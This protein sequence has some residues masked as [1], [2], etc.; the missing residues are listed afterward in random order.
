MAHMRGGLR[1]T[2]KHKRTQPQPDEQEHDSRQDQQPANGTTYPRANVGERE[3]L[4]S[5]IMGVGLL[6]RS[7]RHSFSPVGALGAIGGIALLY[8]AATGYCPAYHALGRGTDDQAD[9]SRI[10]RRKVRTRQ[11][12]KVEESIEIDKPREELYAFWRKLENLPQVMSHVVS[13]TPLDERRSHWTIATVPGAPTIEWDA[14]IISD[15]ENERIGWQT[16]EGASVDHAGSVQFHSAEGE[17]RTLVTVTLQY[18]SP[19]GAMGAAIA[20]L[21]GQDP[22][23]KIAHDLTQFKESMETVAT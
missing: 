20:K 16:V 12:V 4:L 15:V 19:A 17:H 23:R 8:R 10:G 11:A 9:T 5:G 2:T 14:E 7:I 21:F 1:T 3:R 13:V 22:S 18:V 6:A